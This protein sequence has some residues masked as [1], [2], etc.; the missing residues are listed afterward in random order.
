MAV[1]AMFYVVPIAGGP[2]VSNIVARAVEVVKKRGHK[3]MVTPASTI[4]EAASVREALETI[5]EAIEEVKRCEGV[6]RV[7][8][9]IKLDER[10]DKPLSME[11]MVESVREK[12][13]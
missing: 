9:E 2:S 3:Y 13:A 11:S 4:F 12:L 7:I 1:I 6:L 8:A 10:L 5:A